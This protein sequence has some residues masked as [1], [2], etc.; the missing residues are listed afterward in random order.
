MLLIV[1]HTYECHE[2]TKVEGRR[3]PDIGAWVRNDGWKM[4]EKLEM[5]DKLQKLT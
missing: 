1:A 5:H 3:R 2:L 4:N